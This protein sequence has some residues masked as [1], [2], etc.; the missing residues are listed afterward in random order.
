M[1]DLDRVPMPAK[2]LTVQKVGVET[3]ILN[4]AGDQLHTLDETG[5]FLWSKIDGSNSLRAL[6]ELL[7]TEYDV[8]HSQAE[9]D[10]LKFINELEEKKIVA[11][12]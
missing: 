7:C 9:S 12:R 8:A 11:S 2:D 10:L 5:S 3:L 1:E 6:I 4:A